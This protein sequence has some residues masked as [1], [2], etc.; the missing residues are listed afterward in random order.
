MSERGYT[1][2]V[3]PKLVLVLEKNK[4]VRRHAGFF[5][6]R[7]VH[8]T[9]IHWQWLLWKWTCIADKIEGEEARGMYEDHTSG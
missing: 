5:D 3:K 8:G 1:H 4:L 2:L 6:D 9:R 7:D